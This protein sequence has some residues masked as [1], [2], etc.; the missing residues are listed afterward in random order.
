MKKF[1]IIKLKLIFI[2][3]CEYSFPQ[4][5]KQ[6]QVN[7]ARTELYYSIK[8]IDR[9]DFRFQYQEKNGIAYLFE[10][11]KEWIYL[12]TGEYD[13]LI[14]SIKKHDKLYQVR[15]GNRVFISYFKGNLPKKYRF[16]SEK[17]Y[18]FIYKSIIDQL[19]VETKNI[20]SKIEQSEIDKEDKLFLKYFLFLSQNQY[21][22][23]SFLARQERTIDEAK[24]LLAVYPNSKWREFI[25]KY[26]SYKIEPKE[27]GFINI[28]SIGYNSSQGH[29]SDVINYGLSLGSTSTISY[30][31]F[32][33]TVNYSRSIGTQ[34]N[35]IFVDK[36]GWQEVTS[37]FS[38]ISFEPGY[39]FSISKGVNLAP[40][41]GIGHNT[42]SI[43]Q[44][45]ENEEY[46]PLLDRF[47][48]G[49]YSVGLNL[50][51]ISDHTE[52]QNGTFSPSIYN[53]IS[54]SIT[55]I[56]AGITSQTLSNG[57]EKINGNYI[58]MNIGF[59]MYQGGANRTKVKL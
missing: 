21:L 20:I 49:F 9:K 1:L 11:E 54:S 14:S 5:K 18:D 48:G 43:F 47:R 38:R 51:F 42:F 33:F 32:E 17:H 45:I 41:V 3:F 35:D 23:S 13:Q 53:N 27:E 6:K 46:Y 8:N 44:V 29:L 37:R 25:E 34:A 31:N 56:Q 10:H 4:S 40:Y 28:S 58:Y 30:K 19:Q 16:L 15:N 26:S 57:Y 2:L 24:F 52:W 55:R 39:R 59:G 12:L 22:D 50:D 36:M 7:D